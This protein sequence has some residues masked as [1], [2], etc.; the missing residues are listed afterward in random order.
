MRYYRNA[1]THV[2]L[3]DLSQNHGTAEVGRDL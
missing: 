3:P 1:E 2:L